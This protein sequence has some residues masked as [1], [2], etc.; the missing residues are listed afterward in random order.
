[1]LRHN[2]V[3]KSIFEQ[4]NKLKKDF[5]IEGARSSTNFLFLH[6]WRS[7]CDS[8]LSVFSKQIQ[9][10]WCVYAW[11]IYGAAEEEKEE[12]RYFQLYVL[13]LI[14]VEICRTMGVIHSA[15]NNWAHGG[16]LKLGSMSLY[17]YYYY[18]EKSLATC[19]LF[20]VENG[21]VAS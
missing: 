21:L 4:F 7:K 20:I 2:F 18:L 15:A 3:L 13:S 16:F 12:R 11:V 5:K 8:L 9:N 19:Y 1:M 6:K 17:Y 10:D 14:I